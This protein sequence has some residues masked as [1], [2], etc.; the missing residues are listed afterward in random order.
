ML[1]DA[2]HNEKAPLATH[3]GAVIGLSELGTEVSSLIISIIYA[4]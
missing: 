1:S 4:F 3:Y 2:L